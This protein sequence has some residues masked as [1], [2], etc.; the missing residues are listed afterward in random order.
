MY[1]ITASGCYERDS[2]FI[3]EV[4][5]MV[6]NKLKMY[7]DIYHLSNTYSKL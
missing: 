2:L 1:M 6:D 5:I 7:I 4:S 3:P